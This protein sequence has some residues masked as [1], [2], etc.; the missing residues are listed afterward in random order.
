MRLRSI[1]V[2]QADT[3]GLVVK[4]LATTWPN[5]K[6][7]TATIA[8]EL[9]IDRRRVEYYKQAARILGFVRPSSQR[10]EFTETGKQL[11]SSTRRSERTALLR[12][13]VLN[14]PIISKLV[15]D[16]RP[17]ELSDD[18]VRLFLKRNTSLTGTTIPRRAHTI[19]S[20]IH[21]ILDFDPFDPRSVAKKA[22]ESAGPQFEEYRSHEEGYEHRTLKEAIAADP[23]KHLGEPLTLVQI[24][25]PFPTNDRADV[26]FFDKD[27]RFVVVEVEVDVGP[28]DLPGLLQALKYKHMLAVI[29]GVPAEKVRGMLVARSIAPA[30]KERARDY[31]V[32][33]KEV[34]GVI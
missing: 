1:D 17:E 2:P 6:Q 18:R 11:M 21:T 22:S 32:E 20:W 4:L 19:L 14:T 29:S 25:Y 28:R 10:L 31:D 33:C 16:R 30:M 12:N 7:S 34:K 27:E 8:S 23:R 5:G 9:G 13:A 3:L 24:E 26:L 15:K